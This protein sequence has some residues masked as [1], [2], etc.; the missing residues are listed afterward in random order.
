[1]STFQAP[2]PLT[3]HSVLIVWLGIY[4]SS[5]RP[6]SRHETPSYPCYGCGSCFLGNLR[7]ESFYPE[8][9]MCIVYSLTELFNAA[10]AARPGESW[11]RELSLVWNSHSEWHQ[12][13][14][15]SFCVKCS[16]SHQC[17]THTHT[18]VC[19]ERTHTY[20]TGCSCAV[21][22]CSSHHCLQKL[23]TLEIMPFLRIFLQ[24]YIPP[25][26]DINV[27]FPPAYIWLRVSVYLAAKLYRLLFQDHLVDGPPEEGWPLC[28]MGTED[29]KRS[30]QSVTHRVSASVWKYCP[31]C[32]LTVFALINSVY[33]VLFVCSLDPLWLL[34]GNKR[35]RRTW[36]IKLT[37]HGDLC[38][39]A[40][41]LSDH[42]GSHT[43]VH[44]S[45][46]LSRVGDHQL[47]PS[48][49]KKTKQFHVNTQ[50]I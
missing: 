37:K 4:L 18:P 8:C 44:A 28:R 33:L 7:V 6:L 5:C 49:L 39:L 25:T 31:S 11:Q 13:L 12:C 46:T 50:I 10:L 20:K 19:K 43:D 29:K 42:V 2:C 41:P 35:F 45:V 3:C 16:L 27:I 36:E 17:C 40:V 48:D 9:A 24:I 22:V 47:P 1:M 32:L 34:N 26:R 21:T 23:S 30:F 14:H 15:C 38:C